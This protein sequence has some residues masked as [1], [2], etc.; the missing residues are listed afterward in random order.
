L[1]ISRA[2]NPSIGTRISSRLIDAERTSVLTI[3]ETP[4]RGRGVGPA[5]L[6]RP[7]PR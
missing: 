4:S 2:T 7:P 3:A 1:A 5:H 6:S